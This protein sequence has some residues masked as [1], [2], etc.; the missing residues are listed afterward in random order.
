MPPTL[1]RVWLAVVFLASGTIYGWS[2]PTTLVPLACAAAPAAL[3]LML[4]GPVRV[5]GV[6]ALAFVL[7]AGNAALRAHD[8][9][10]LEV[11]AHDVPRC[12]VTGRVLEEAGGLGTLV[13]IRRL[14]CPG[15]REVSDA[16]TVFFDGAV[17]HAGSGIRA[18]G[19]LLPLTDDGFGRA[20][21]NLGA[22][23]SFHSVELDVLTPP[24]GA[25]AVAASIRQGLHTA[26]AA[27]QARRAA[28]LHGL[29]IGETSGLDPATVETFR[30]A[31]LSHLLAVSG[32]NVAIVLGAVA[33][34]ARRL[35][36]APRIALG[37][38]C[39]G[40]FV[41]TVGPDP[42]VLR[43][44]VMGAIGL[45][46]IAWGRRA[47]PLH[48]LGLAILLLL[49]LRPGL[50]FSAGLHLSAAA[51]AGIVLWSAPLAARLS[52][53]PRVAA[54]PLAA[55]LAAQAAVMPVLLATFGEVSLIAPAANLLAVP[56]VAP[57][58]VGGLVAA[59]S[60]IIHGGFGGALARPL[61]PLAGWVLWVADTGAAVPWAAVSV[62]RPFGLVAA[63]PVLLQA[64]RTLMTWGDRTRRAALAMSRVPNMPD[65]HWVLHDVSGKDLGPTQPCP[66]RGEAE[67]FMGREWA[68]LLEEGAHSATLV[69][70]GKKLY[71]MGLTAE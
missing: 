68:A 41:V 58:T 27:L 33:L 23:A 63:V 40:L 66:S 39:L 71:T 45:A 47:E 3:A 42:S 26:T 54:V 32:T 7:G 4:R 6:A 10:P 25:F 18:Q 29:T 70:D 59:C 28:L 15:R 17:G 43:A 16:G 31:G 48:A 56:V 67:D 65:Y 24:G 21:R 1:I 2:R 19:W 37:A 35:P 38:I 49:G 62:P 64:A 5:A 50:V 69:G 60:A 57:A 52:W 30:R 44:A 8:R 11:M 55:T 51:T 34:V 61:E 9:G 22:D 13:A 46:A 36:L 20:R 12:T 53:L 14:L